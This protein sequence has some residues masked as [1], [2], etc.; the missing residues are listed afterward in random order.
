MHIS[1]PLALKYGNKLLVRSLIW[2][3]QVVQEVQF[4]ALEGYLKSK[5]PNIKIIGVDAY[6]SVLKKFHETSEF[7]ENEIYPYRIEG[8]GKNLIPST[9]HFEYIDHFEKV[10]D[11]ESAHAA[12][13][14]T[15][16]DGIFVG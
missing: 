15:T 2:W 14:I 16:T 13:E 8:L 12:R 5:N 10:T 6:G 11:E 1:K 4:L 3:Q 7:D 9:T